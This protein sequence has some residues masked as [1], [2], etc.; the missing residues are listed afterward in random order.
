MAVYVGKAVE[1][2]LDIIYGAGLDVADEPA[3]LALG[4]EQT[5]EVNPAPL[6]DDARGLADIAFLLGTL[7]HGT[8]V[9]TQGDVVVFQPLAQAGGVDDIVVEVVCRDIV[10]RCIAQC[11]QYLDALHNLTHGER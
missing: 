7:Q 11:L 4:H 3:L 5:A 10:A 8:H 6:A 9:D 1:H 2:L